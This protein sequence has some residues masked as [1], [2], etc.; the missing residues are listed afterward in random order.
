ML[1]CFEYQNRVKKIVTVT[2]NNWTNDVQN[3][4]HTVFKTVVRPTNQTTKIKEN[5]SRKKLIQT[6]FGFFNKQTK[7]H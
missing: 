2:K 5:I 6:N 1:M 4:N 7:T 3:V